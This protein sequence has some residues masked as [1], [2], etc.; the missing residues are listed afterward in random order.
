MKRLAIWLSLC[1]SVCALDGSAAGE[2]GNRSVRAHFMLD[3]RVIDARD[4]MAMVSN[5]Y[6]GGRE[7]AVEIIFSPNVIPEAV[8]KDVLERRE[9]RYWEET[10]AAQLEL[11]VDENNRVWMVNLAVIV[12]GEQGRM[13]RDRI[14]EG[15]EEVEARGIFSFDGHRVKIKSKGTYTASEARPGAYE[16]DVETELPVFD[17]RKKVDAA[18]K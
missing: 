4:A 7:T 5:H 11:F 6:F 17:I 3:G 8:K 15:R 12:M 10:G 1:L 14:A 18:K 16:W 13:Q 2:G 9:S